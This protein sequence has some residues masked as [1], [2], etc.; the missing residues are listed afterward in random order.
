MN[1]KTFAAFF[2]I[3]LASVVATASAQ[4]DGPFVAGT[5][6]PDPLPEGAQGGNIIQINPGDL[7]CEGILDFE[8]V[9][10]GDAPGT[11]YDAVLDLD[12]GAISERFVGQTLNFNGNFDVLGGIPTGPLSSQVGDPNDNFCV[13]I[14]GTQVLAGNG[15]I[16]WPDFDAIGEGAIAVLFDFD[17]SQIGFAVVGA[18]GGNAIV[19]FFRRDGSNIDTFTLPNLDNLVYAF[20]RVGGVEDIAG[21]SIYNDDPAGIGFD[22]ICF[23]VTEPTPTESHTWGRIKTIYE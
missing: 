20:E 6:P 22:D 14:S 21:F 2:L 7:T 9:A 1:S 17:Q 18:E 23:N 10:G 4:T 16:G 12:G 11:N 15:P 5:P 19:D 3:A 13:L 8:D